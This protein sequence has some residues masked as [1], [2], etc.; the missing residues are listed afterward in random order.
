MKAID[1]LHE[2][3]ISLEEL[4][5]FLGLTRKRALDMVSLDRKRHDFIPG[6]KASAGVYYFRYE[7]VEAYLL[8]QA[9]RSQNSEEKAETD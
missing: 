9:T 2:E 7:D 1:Q 8:S 4:C 3:F 5:V 6:F